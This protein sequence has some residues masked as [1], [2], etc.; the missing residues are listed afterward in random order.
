MDKFMYKVFVFA[1]RDEK[2]IRK[3]IDAASNAGAG[4]IGKYNKCAF[5]TE[6]IGAWKAEKNA[7]PA[8]GEVG[9]LQNIKEVKIEMQCSDKSI[10]QV[11]SSIKKVHP[12]EEVVI[13]VFR[14]ETFK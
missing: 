14:M 9:K 6:G 5:I 13:D 1:P 11:L 10:K 7:H 4:K 2:I 3:I 12:Y 8:I